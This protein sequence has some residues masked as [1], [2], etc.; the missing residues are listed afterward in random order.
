MADVIEISDGEGDWQT[1]ND[2]S[3]T[4]Q[5]VIDISSEAPEANPILN[6]DQI[7][8]KVLEMV[9]DVA[10]E[11]LESLVAKLLEEGDTR[12]CVERVIHA[13]FEAPSY[14]K[15][16]SQKGKKRKREGS[17]SGEGGP[18]TKVVRSEIDYGSKDR[19]FKG[20]YQYPILA[21]NQLSIDFPFIPVPHI[22][23]VLRSN[24]HLYAPTHLQLLKDKSSENPPYKTK[25][26]KTKVS[27]KCSAVDQE[28]LAEREWLET[29]LK[30]QADAPNRV[31]V[32]QADEEVDGGIECGCCFS[33]YS[34]VSLPAPRIDPRFEFILRT[35]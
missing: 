15:H 28:Y 1:A 10:L 18:S 27:G 23:A 9:P 30:H 16:D 14:P 32:E 21:L 31:A 20:G 33:C 35:K 6:L 34:F 12:S 2:G 8:A 3:K 29:Y 5:R 13:L 7:V 4:E 24:N 11:H 25:V 26:T 17:D 19:I 22:R